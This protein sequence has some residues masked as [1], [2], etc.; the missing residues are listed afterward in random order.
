MI[1]LHCHYLPFVDDGAQT[2]VES[3]TLAAMSVAQGIT[4]AVLTPHLYA[5]RWENTLEATRAPF[6]AYRTMLE[7]SGVSIGLRLAAEVHL[8][9]ESL[10][11]AQRGALPVLGHWHGEGV[12]LLE[13][14][15]GHVPPGTD[16]AVALLR[17][18]GYLPM[19]AHPERNKSVMRDIRVLRPLVEAGCLVQL[20]AASVIG[21]FGE[22]AYR[23]ARQLLDVGCVTAVATDAH[24]LAHR[25]PRLREA[26]DELARGWGEE[27]AE[28]LTRGNPGRIIGVTTEAPQAVAGAVSAADPAAASD[29]PAASSSTGG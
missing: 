21:A 1:D 11:L 17:S 26:R 28:R 8:L 12:V 15:D 22:P 5:G 13:L 14:P 9:P 24:N 29:P 3:A 2:I 7:R 10:E 20:T 23:C 6:E 27:V 19:L 4:H 16:K 18:L 25:P